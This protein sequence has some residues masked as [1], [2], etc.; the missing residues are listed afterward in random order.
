MSW[1]LRETFSVADHLQPRAFGAD[2]LVYNCLLVPVP[3]GSDFDGSEKQCWKPALQRTKLDLLKDGGV[4]VEEIERD[5]TRREHASSG[6]GTLTR[7]DA[8]PVRD[9]PVATDLVTRARDGDKQAWDALV[10]RYT[11]LIWSI[12]RR[13]RLGRADAEDVGQSVWLQ[14][15]DQLDKIRDPAALPGWL[16]TTTRRACRKV[17]RGLRAA[18]Y[19]LDVEEIPDERTRTAEQE[20]LTAERHAALRDAYG[21]LPPLCQQ[22]IAMLTADPP[23]PYANISAGLGIPIGSIGPSRGRCLD[24]LR[25]HPAIA[26][27]ISAEA[28]TEL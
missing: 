20:V 16:A 12:C 23:V 6:T 13:H 24:K 1:Q 5:A 8:R 15:V 26:A 4:R 2:D 21:D 27:L 28:E 9:D 18:R 25:R 14:L 10:E 22:L 7:E 3:D 17:L 11:P 19:G